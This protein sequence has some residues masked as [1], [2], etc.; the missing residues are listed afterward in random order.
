MECIYKKFVKRFIMINA[1]IVCLVIASIYMIAEIFKENYS[2]KEIL[3]DYENVLYGSAFKDGGLI[4]L[5]IVKDKKPAV[6]ALGSS[7]VMQ[8]RADFFRG[9]DFYTLGGLG[10]SIDELEYTWS[11][12]KVTYI[13]KVVIIGIDPWWLNPNMKQVNR[14][15]NNSEDDVKY[16]IINELKRNKK[17]RRQ[18][19]HLDEIKDKDELGGRKNIGLNAAVNGNGYRLSDGSYQYGKIIKDKEDNETRFKS[20]YERLEKGAIGDRFVWCDTISDSELKKLKKLL[21]DINESGA[22]EVVFFPPFPHEVYSYMDNNVHFHDYLHDYMYG[23]NQIC[24]ELE[25]PCYNFCDL[26]L[27][28]ASDD[29]AVD[30]F[31]GSD[32]AYARI[33][34]L[35]GRDAP[36]SRYVDY[37]K[38]QD[39]INNRIDSMQVI[40]AWY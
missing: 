23:V 39:A 14:L 13:P 28:G 7:R 35:L 20:T 37:E 19:L 34:A 40:P 11:K 29:E 36:L 33:T 12:I 38:T 4:K 21:Q 26:A 25:I 10:S 6:I 9:R 3:Q 5:D 31:H 2:D 16:K 15:I 32:V 30:G 22:E 18:L 27:T 17:M 1:L 24:S 8:F